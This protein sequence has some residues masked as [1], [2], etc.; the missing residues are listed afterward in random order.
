MAPDLEGR[1][2]L[3]AATSAWVNW[4]NHVRPHRTNPD[5]L[6]PAAAENHYEGL[7]SFLCKRVV[8]RW[9]LIRSG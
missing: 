2:D 8:Q 3:E 5:E 1:D 6:P 4:Y 7:S 9:G